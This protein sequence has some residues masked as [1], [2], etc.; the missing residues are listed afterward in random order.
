MPQARAR[1]FHRHCPAFCRQLVQPF[2]GFPG[3]R[4]GR[5]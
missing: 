2:Q 1:F 3:W 4:R 5:D